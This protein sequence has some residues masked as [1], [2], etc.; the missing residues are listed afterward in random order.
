MRIVSRLAARISSHPRGMAPGLWM[1]TG[2]G[3]ST[4]TRARITLRTSASGLVRY[5]RQRTVSLLLG[6]GAS[7]DCGGQLIGSVPLELERV[8]HDQGITGI[9]PPR[10]RRWLVTLYLAVRYAG[11]DEDT[12]VTRQ[13][14]LA[15]RDAVDSGEAE[16]LPVNFEAV[17]ATLHR[18]RSAL[19]ETGGRLR[20][21]GTLPVNVRSS[22]LDESV[23]RAT[24]ALACACDLPTEEGKGGL[25]A[26]SA[27]LR[28]LLTRPL[29][30]KRVNVF[31]LNYDTLVEQAAGRHRNR[32]ARWLRRNA[33]PSPSARELRPRP[34]LPG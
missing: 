24:N 33:E 20:I 8:L 12:P 15:R 14:I 16:P 1:Q 4:L 18:W 11:G 17:L 3:R 7:V 31:T 30:L 34:L 10:L 9:R 5:S 27:L 13:A 19:S 29:N 22:E 23:R 6:A 26:Y 21:D 2:N 25:A 28:K 32:P